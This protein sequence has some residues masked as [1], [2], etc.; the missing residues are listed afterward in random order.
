ME[1]PNPQSF[2]TAK[3]PMNKQDCSIKLKLKSDK[4]LDYDISIYYIEDLLYF[5]E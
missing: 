4:N 5:V 2:I 3:E 1:A